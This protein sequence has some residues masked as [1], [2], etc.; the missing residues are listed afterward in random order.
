MGARK[1]E[2][3][4]LS[5]YIDNILITEVSITSL[6]KSFASVGYNECIFSLKDFIV[7]S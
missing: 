6:F 2:S 1:V 7:G 3:V 5:E 4:R